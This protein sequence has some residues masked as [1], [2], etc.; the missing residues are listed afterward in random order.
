M[1]PNVIFKAALLVFFNSNTAEKHKFVNFALGHFKRN[2]RAPP[3]HGNFETADSDFKN[4]FLIY[5]VSLAVRL[6]FASI[7][8]LVSVA[9]NAAISS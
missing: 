3:V 7:M 2:H 9:A 8:I 5:V 4:S 1:Q 6:N